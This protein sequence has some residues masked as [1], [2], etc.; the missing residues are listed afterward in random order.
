MDMENV[1]INGAA[2]V[3]YLSPE[4]K[5]AVK[6]MVRRAW[7]VRGKITYLDFSVVLMDMEDLQEGKMH[8]FVGMRQQAEES[9]I[10]HTLNSSRLINLAPDGS[11][12]LVNPFLGELKSYQVFAKDYPDFCGVDNVVT[13]SYE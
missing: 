5:V 9:E 8:V 13:K 4:Q 3:K 7:E 10:S 1:K 6:E 2:M 12:Y 11:C